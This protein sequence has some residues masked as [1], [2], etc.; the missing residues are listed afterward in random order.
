MAMG[1]QWLHVR[2]VIW[3]QQSAMFFSEN[4]W[5]PDLLQYI[6]SN[7]GDLWA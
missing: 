2:G 4:W 5:L 3:S 6:I 7:S 1:R